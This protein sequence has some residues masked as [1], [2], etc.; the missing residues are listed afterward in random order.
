MKTTKPDEL[1]PN[2]AES[3]ALEWLT[4]TEAR[5]RGASGLARPLDK[6]A[7]LVGA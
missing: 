2:E 3:K 7:K 1:V 5:D 4:L 6:I